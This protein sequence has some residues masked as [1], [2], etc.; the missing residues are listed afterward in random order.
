MFKIANMCFISINQPKPF[1]KSNIREYYKMNRFHMSKKPIFFLSFLCF[2]FLLSAQTLKG[3]VYDAESTVKGLKI[4]NL[5]QKTET[6]TDEN[7]DFIIKAKVNDS[8]FFQSL[9]HHPKT[10]VVSEKQLN[11]LIVF[12]LKK[13][14]N[15][16]D[17]VLISEDPKEKPFKEEAYNTNLK[18]IIEEDKKNNPHLYNAAPKY[19]L[20]FVQLIG[21]VVK[22]FRK[23]KS[24]EDIFSAIK[25]DQLSVL[26]KN[27]SFF[28]DKLLANGLNI[29]KDYKY[30]FFEFCEAQQIN[31]QLLHKDKKLELLDKLVL[32]SQR[33]LLLVETATTED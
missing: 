8:I 12:E 18:N 2:T 33:F 14:V 29:P 11:Q 16:L 17:E 25:Y 23:K 31:S 6:Q 1:M 19:G 15:E 26:F 22:L 24:Q 5:T 21:Y 7:G 3:K 9:F 13:A 20:D 28:N 4:Y 32:C 10:I 30:L 27:N